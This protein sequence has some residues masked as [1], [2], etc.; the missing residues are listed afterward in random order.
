MNRRHLSFLLAL[1]MLSV[2]FAWAQTTGD[3]RSNAANFNWNT[4]ASWQRWDGDSWEV[5]TGAQGYPG[6]TAASIAGTVTIQAGHTVTGNVD[7][8]AND[9]GNL[10]ING[11]L[12]VNNNNID[13]DMTGDLTIAG[14]FDMNGD[15]AT[16]DIGGDVSLSGNGILN[17]DDND[18]RIGIVGNLSIVGN[19]VF[20]MNDDDNTV[21]VGGDLSLSANGIL[22]MNG[23]NEDQEMNVAGNLTM[24]G[25]SEIQGNDSDC[26][27]DVDGTFTVPASATNARVAGIT[28]TI[29]G[30]TTVAGTLTFNDNDGVK[31]FNG[32][33]IVS[34]SWTSTA[35][36]SNDRLVFRSEVLTSG[37]FNPGCQ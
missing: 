34:G 16:V 25:A 32:T 29:D 12:I 11:S 22:D 31:R 27:L 7:V 26:E 35:I 9:I 33:V 30:A 4:D 20:N 13:I 8:T 15:N 5:P 3:Y 18:I 10:M 23:N 19:S 17:M 37:T 24:D 21:D 6:E 28:F 2:Q 36:T 1:V 14:L